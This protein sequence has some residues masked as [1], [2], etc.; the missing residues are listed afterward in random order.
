MPPKSRQTDAPHEPAT[1]A[2]T[3]EQGENLR[4]VLQSFLDQIGPQYQHQEKM[5]STLYAYC[6]AKVNGQPYD[7]DVFWGRKDTCAR[8]TWF[9]WKKSHPAYTELLR[10]AAE[11]A[12]AWRNEVATEA[13]QEAV[14]IL[15]LGAVQAARQLVTLTQ[16][17]RSEHVQLGAA[18]SV[19][20]RADKTTAPKDNTL[21]IPGLEDAIRQI[22]GS[23]MDEG[24]GE[25]A[26]PS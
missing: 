19:L 17:A 3:P 16:A 4:D 12:L 25:E 7:T 6:E 20:D 21:N 1:P 18:N 9:K 2:I 26:T 22:Y 11:K 10:Q 8:S 13:V 5:Q 24:E 23:E 14:I 15:Q